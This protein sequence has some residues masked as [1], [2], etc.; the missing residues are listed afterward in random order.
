MNEEIIQT[1]EKLETNLKNIK[2]LYIQKKQIPEKAKL[3]AY[4]LRTTLDLTKMRAA[5]KKYFVGGAN[6]K[7]SYVGEWKEKARN[8]V[9]PTPTPPQ[10]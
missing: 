2:T 6:L 1:I 3:E 7:E 8:K 10:N 4:L 9:T 5:E